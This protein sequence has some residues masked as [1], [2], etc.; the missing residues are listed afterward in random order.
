MKHPNPYSEPYKET[1]R[2]LKTELKKAAKSN[3]CN[4]TKDVIWFVEKEFFCRASI[5]LS[6]VEPLIEVSSSVKTIEDD[7]LLWDIVDMSSNKSEPMSLRAYGV[8]SLPGYPVLDGL[9]YRV[10]DD[11]RLDVYANKIVKDFYHLSKSF[12]ESINY[13]SKE[14]Q[15]SVIALDFEKRL[16]QRLEIA[17][18]SLG[19]YQEAKDLAQ[20]AIDNGDRMIR[21]ANGNK[22]DLEYIIEFCNAKLSGE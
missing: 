9:I 21:F 18:I 22:S 14:Y 15:H 8:F 20:R 6:K 4:Y 17:L 2:D 13:S 16:S 11:S 7:N 10:E 19:E 12:I 5:F 1:Y 3:K